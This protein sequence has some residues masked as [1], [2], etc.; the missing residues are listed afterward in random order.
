LRREPLELRQLLGIL[1]KRFQRL[2]VR[3]PLAIE[4]Q[5][6]PEPGAE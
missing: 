3:D 1:G 2:G 6:S 5:I 4:L